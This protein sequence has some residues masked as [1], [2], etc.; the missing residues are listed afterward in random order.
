MLLE[1][2]EECGSSGAEVGLTGFF[3]FVVVFEVV[4]LVFEL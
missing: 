4:D 1:G 2:W 3:T